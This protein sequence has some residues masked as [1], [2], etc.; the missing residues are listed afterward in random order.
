MSR[1]LG[2]LLLFL[3][4]CGIFGY[5]ALDP[6]KA[7]VKG[8]DLDAQLRVLLRRAEAL[9]RERPECTAKT[10]RNWPNTPVILIA[11]DTLR[12]DRL[13]SYG[14]SRPVSPEIDRLAGDSL[15][16]ER[17]VAPA[18]WT[19]PSFAS[20]FTGYAPAALGIRDEPIPL[21]REVTTLSEV[22]CEAG[23]STAGVVS[24]TYVGRR[25][26]FDRGF[27]EWDESQ[28]AGPAHV[29][30]EAVT[31]AALAALERLS[32]DDEPFLLVVHY[33]DPHYNYREH[34]GFR[35]SRGAAAV[36]NREFEDVRALRKLAADGRLAHSERRLLRDRYDSEIA[37][38]D[39]HIGRLLE[40]LRDLQLYHKALVVFLADHGEM[41][42]ERKDQW[43]GHTRYLYQSTIHVPLMIKL[44]YRERAGRVRGPV[45]TQNIGATILDWLGAE[46][47]LP[48][49]S[50]IDPTA[51]DQPVFAQTRRWATRDAVYDGGWKLIRDEE[52]GRIELYDLDSDPNERLDRALEE[53][54]RLAAMRQMLDK[55]VAAQSN[56]SS[57]FSRDELAPLTASERAR[58][59]ALG[60][61]E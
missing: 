17:A 27:V 50:L 15:V 26:G 48:G 18:P 61:V 4:T 39:Y 19:T 41:F 25:Y 10:G 43:I 52:A 7:A 12:A 23:I 42:A 34:A 35:F 36:A 45:S 13:G 16:F 47:V 5:L 53:P 29:S 20:V 51:A 37:F 2:W 44:P 49:V 8:T 1:T 30:S 11:V 58:L 40:R 31:H 55:W 28:A 22:F 3:A 38:T 46:P 21:P 9:S 56:R 14:Y 33:F 60:Y 59:E 54:D 6:L 24:H 57:A 32:V